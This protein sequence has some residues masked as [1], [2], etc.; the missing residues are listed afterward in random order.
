MFEFPARSLCP[1][2]LG[3]GVEKERLRMV[4]VSSAMGRQLADNIID[5]VE[6][7]TALG[8]NPLKK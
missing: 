8:P 1:G 7:V 2:K 3:I 5:M 6:T 4:N